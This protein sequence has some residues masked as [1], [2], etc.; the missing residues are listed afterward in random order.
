MD[1]NINVKCIKCTK[2]FKLK[3]KYCEEE[4]CSRCILVD[5]HKCSNIEGK[6]K[7]DLSILNTNIGKVVSSSKILKI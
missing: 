4:Y 1:N 7:K 6:N 5:I 2:F 3:C